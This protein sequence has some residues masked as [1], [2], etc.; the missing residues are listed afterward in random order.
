M[1][2]QGCYPPIMENQMEQNMENQMEQKTEN[3]MEQKIENDMEKLGNVQVLRREYIGVQG[4]GVFV[5]GVRMENQRG[6]LGVYRDQGLG[7]GAKVYTGVYRRITQGLYRD[8]G[9]ENGSY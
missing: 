5:A 7:L 2:G 6:N 8:N 3:Q 9:K 4:L 1:G